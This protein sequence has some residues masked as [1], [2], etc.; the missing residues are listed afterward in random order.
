VSALVFRFPMPPNLANARMHWRVKN[1]ERQAYLGLLDGLQLAGRLPAPPAAPFARAA[2]RSAMVVGGAMDDDNAMARHKW[3]LDWLKTRGY[4]VDDRRT[5]LR[6][7]DFPAQ[8]VKRTRGVE[9]HIEL[10]VRA[11]GREEAA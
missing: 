5:C 2:I 3:A 10:T 7:E 8:L 4:I 6:W 1:R 11:L 9:H